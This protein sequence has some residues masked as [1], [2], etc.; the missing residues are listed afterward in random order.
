MKNRPKQA[1]FTLLELLVVVTI[2]GIL[3]GM[4]LPALARAK[5][6]ARRVECSSD[7]RQLNLALLLFADEHEDEFPARARRANSWISQLK[8]YYLEPKILQCPADG[9]FSDRSYII[10]GFND[11][12]EAALSPQ[13]Y[14]RYKNWSYPRGMMLGG[15]PRP[16]DTITFGEK[17]RDS[18]QVHMDFYQGLGND[19]EE[20]DHGK[21]TDAN[22]KAGGA[23][24]SFADG[25]VRFVKYWRSLSP[26]NLWAVTDL[27]RLQ[28][29]AEPTQAP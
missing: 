4:L 27:Y 19:V 17:L 21:H 11:W 26:E 13:D 14:E 1:G 24:F 8:S 29:I 10:N 15:I 20:V 9:W 28:P 23:N 18:R 16:T 25:S 12:F 5:G 22:R 2:I 7:Q 3:A 6:R